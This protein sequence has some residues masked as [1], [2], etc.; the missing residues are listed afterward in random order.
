M[1][2]RKPRNTLPDKHMIANP[3]RSIRVYGEITREMVSELAPHILTLKEASGDPI[4]VF[5]DS[6]G[7]ISDGAVALSGILKSPDQKGR[8]CWMNAVVTGQACSAAAHLLAV[9][10]YAIA[11]RH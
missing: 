9:A 7:G 8:K 1:A 10:D 2:K 5:I 6:P 11:Y 3:D 4:T